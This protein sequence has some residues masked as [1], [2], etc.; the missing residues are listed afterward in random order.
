[1]INKHAIIIV[2]TTQKTK[3]KKT[4]PQT[5]KKSEKYF[6]FFIFIL[7]IFINLGKKLQVCKRL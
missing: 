1:M 2:Q 6:N 4:H 7:F 3:H 5:I